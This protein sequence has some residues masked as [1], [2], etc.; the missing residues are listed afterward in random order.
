MLEELFWGPGGWC[1]GVG[2][3]WACRKSWH[4]KLCLLVSGSK[5][6]P[7][8]QQTA[9]LTVS[10]MGSRVQQPVG[11]PSW[12]FYLLCN[13]VSLTT[14][15]SLR[16]L[17]CERLIR[18]KSLSPGS[19][20]DEMRPA[21]GACPARMQVLQARPQFTWLSPTISLAPRPV[22]TDSLRADSG[23]KGPLAAVRS[24]SKAPYLW[25]TAL[26]GRVNPFHPWRN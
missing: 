25:Y 12:A 11:D 24:S 10:S 18:L 23:G 17:I 22:L 13:F 20:E 26:Q 3:F 21:G 5:P 7:Y 16:A 9:L 8:S 1:M 2:E 14:S 15:L 6:G 4:R 19:S